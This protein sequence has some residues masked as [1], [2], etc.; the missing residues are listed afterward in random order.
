MDDGFLAAVFFRQM[1]E[2]PFAI[3]KVK[4]PESHGDIFRFV[5]HLRHGW[6]GQR[7]TGA[8]ADPARRVSARPG[9]P[10]IRQ[11]KLLS[12]QIR[13][14]MAR[15]IRVSDLTRSGRQPSGKGMVL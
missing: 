7:G 15:M 3:L 9:T 4:N 1:G 2:I 10:S 13:K 8:P 11:T 6:K 12:S 14:S 5:W